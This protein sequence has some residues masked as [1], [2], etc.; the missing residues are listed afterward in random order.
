VSR[1]GGDRL[2]EDIFAMLDGDPGIEGVRNAIT[3]WLPQT[4]IHN[5]SAWIDLRQRIMLRTNATQKVV[6]TGG[7]LDDEGQSLNATMAADNANQERLS[8]LTMSRWRAQLFA[9]HC[10]HGVCTAMSQSGLSGAYYG[11][12]P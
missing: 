10:L 6:N 12:Q 5:F 11:C 3:G 9:L 7:N 1:I 4:A 8:T 2:V